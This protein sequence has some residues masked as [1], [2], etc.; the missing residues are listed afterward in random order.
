MTLKSLKP[1]VSR[2]WLIA[3]AGLMWSV[4]GLMLCRL[5]YHWVAAIRWSWV[6]PLELLSIVLALIAY[7]LCFSKIAKKNIVRLSLLKE[8]T[9]IFA[10]QRW[11]SYF[12]VGLMITLGITLRNLPIPRF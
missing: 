6:A 5:A 1:A 11:K 3:L 12:L 9:C 8:K 10:F 2:T 4:V 7:Q